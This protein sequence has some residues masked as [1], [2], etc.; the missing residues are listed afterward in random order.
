[1]LKLDRTVLKDTSA[2]TLINTDFSAIEL[3]F[4]DKD[5]DEAWAG[6]LGVGIGTCILYS[7]IGSTALLTLI[8]A[9]CKYTNPS[10]ETYWNSFLMYLIFQYQC[11][12]PTLSP[13]ESKMDR[14][15]GL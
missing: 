12:S 9:S 3:A 14:R 10:L 6:V 4:L 7:L 1:M 15:N 8:P 11:T 2:L 13:Q 5:Q